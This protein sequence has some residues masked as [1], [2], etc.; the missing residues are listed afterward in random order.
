MR[1]SSFILFKG[2]KMPTHDQMNKMD[3]HDVIYDVDQE[4]RDVVIEL[5]DHG[6][7]TLGS[8]AGHRPN[9]IGGFISI[10]GRPTDQKVKSVKTILRKYGLT[11]IGNIVDNE[12]W[13]SVHFASI[14]IHEF[15]E[16]YKEKMRNY[17]KGKK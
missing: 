6:F 3:K 12:K 5:N 11:H 8:C 14:G 7:K 17:Y 10:S 16:Q 1:G 13:W 15:R 2:M 9:K 4:I